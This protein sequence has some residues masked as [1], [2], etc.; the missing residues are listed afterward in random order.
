MSIF[1]YVLEMIGT[2]AFAVSGAMI[3]V[4]KRL[5]IVGVIFLGVITAVGGGA[6]RDLMIGVT[7]PM[8]FQNPIYLVTACVTS[9]LFFLPFVRRPLVRHQKQFDLLLFIMDSLGL[10]VFTVSGIQSCIHVHPTASPILLIFVGVLT[11]TGG[12]VVRDALAGI[13]PMVFVKH[14][15]ATASLAGAALYTGLHMVGADTQIAGAISAVL[16][17]AIRCLAAHYHWNM[18]RAQE[19]V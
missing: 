1:L 4:R 8:C 18:P 11:A 7:P 16:V 17:F 6:L 10:A 9:F 2:V 19:E 3:A 13:T 15:Y 14:V 5:D 12:G